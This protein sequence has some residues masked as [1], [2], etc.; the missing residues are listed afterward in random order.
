M[1]FFSIDAWAVT[2]LC[3]IMGRRGSDKGHSDAWYSWHN[4][5]MVY[6][7]LFESIRSQPLRIFELGLGTNNVKIPSSMHTS[8]TPGS[9]LRGWA[10]YFP[11][12][13]VY[14]ADIDHEILFEEPRIMTY[15]C[16]QT[17]PYSIKTLWDHKELD[18]PVDII[19]DDGLH[20]FT[21]NVCFFENSIHKLKQ[22]GFFIIEDIKKSEWNLFEEQVEVW[23]SK[24]PSFQ[25]WLLKVPSL[26]NEQDN[27]MLLV[28]S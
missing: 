25:F 8:Y 10:E 16:D 20:T 7:Q 6:Y 1:S 4:Y 5:T 14:G 26:R 24:Y 21:A 3:E 28:M 18:M 22:G 17:K 13:F 12:A 19:I 9:S 27:N 15:F 11:N 23:K 2:P